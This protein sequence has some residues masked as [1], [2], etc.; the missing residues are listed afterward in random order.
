M[1]STILE[2]ARSSHEDIELFERAVVQLM[3]DEP[4]TH[5]DNIIQAHKVNQIV[6]KIEDRTKKLVEI[7]QDL[8]GSR[9][10]E[11]AAMG[12]SSGPNL[13]STFYDRL[14][15]LKEYHRRFPNLEPDRPE[16]ET[17]L[18]TFGDEPPVQFSGEE[19][20]GK[21]LDLHSLFVRYVNLKGVKQLD[22]MTYLD[23]F[24]KFSDKNVTKDTIYSSYLKDLQE[25]LVSFIKRS[26]P[27]LDINRLTREYT[28][29]FM[30][31]WRSGQF[32]P[33][34]EE[35]AKNANGHEEG[36]NGEKMDTENANGDAHKENGAQEKPSNEAKNESDPLYCKYCKKTFAKDTVF[37][38]HL[39]GKKHLAAVKKQ[40]GNLEE[41]YKSEVIVNR[42][43]DL[44]LDQIEATKQHIEIKQGLR[45][46][47]LEHENEF[48]EEADDD[49]EEEEEVR[50]TKM[51]YPVGWDGQPIPYWLYKLNGL[52]NEYK[53]EICGNTSYWGRRA[54]EKHFQEWRHQYGLKCLRLESNKA[55]N[56]ITSIQDAIELD[57]K[58][59]ADK[60]TGV[61]NPDENEEYE[62]ADGNVLSKKTYQLLKMQ[63]LA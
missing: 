48:E 59:R 42:L 30:N 20:Y 46:E 6:E 54:F 1:S 14:R 28:E 43:A 13:Y 24:Y 55:F 11:I 35:E 51:N 26:Q 36:A 23:T 52:G 37:T 3:L 10:D 34:G 49:E 9:K 7:Y 62:D 21:Y 47:E 32:V 17:I 50:L 4:R 57:K 33:I 18:N 44:L 5:K 53:C 31:Q 40:T 2:T 25:Y 12:A 22:Y 41:V 27:L 63:G 45:P 19:G 16:A 8:D 56:E 38:A 29:E 39:K 61:W 60:K 58:L 15:E